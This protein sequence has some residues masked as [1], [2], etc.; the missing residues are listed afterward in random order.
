MKTA[1]RGNA[2]EGAVLNALI[3]R[4]HDV[5]LPFGDG[6]PFDLVIH[7]RGRFIRVQVKTAWRKEGCVLFNPYATDHGKGI[8][9]YAGLADVFGVFCR[10]TDAIYL[11]PLDG[12]ASQSGRLRIEPT[13][14]NQSRRVRY[15][16]QFEISK[17]DEDRLLGL[18]EERPD[19]PQLN[20]DVA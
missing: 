14:N 2:A 17:W 12:V 19:F 15:A 13:R 5:L 16:H 18:L 20:I 9:S 6:H 8:G 7:L 3:R 1:T 4:G 11:V 10:D